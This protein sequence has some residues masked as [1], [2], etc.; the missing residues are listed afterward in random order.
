M[1]SNK[2]HP[3]EF[4]FMN[5]A[6][7]TL[8]VASQNHGIILKTKKRSEEIHTKHIMYRLW[9]NIILSHGTCVNN[10]KFPKLHF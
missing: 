7:I 1:G 8:L 5:V 4:F 10:L 9:K 6:P 3:S 2:H